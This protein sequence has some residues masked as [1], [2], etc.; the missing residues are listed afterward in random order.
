MNNYLLFVEKTKIMK[1]RPDMV[2]FLKKSTPRMQFI[3]GISD[4]AISV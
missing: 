1:K 2:Q 4:H 3:M